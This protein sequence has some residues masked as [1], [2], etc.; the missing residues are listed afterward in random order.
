MD[1]KFS[2]C[3][4]YRQLK[5]QKFEKNS[6]KTKVRKAREAFIAPKSCIKTDRSTQFKISILKAGDY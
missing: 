2:K 3:K 5:S 1:A 6:K 4:T